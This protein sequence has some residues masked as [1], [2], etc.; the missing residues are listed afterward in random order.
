M[1]EG[2]FYAPTVGLPLITQNGKSCNPG[3]LQHSV[4][5]SLETCLPIGIPK[6]PQSLDIRKNSGRRIS[7]F[8]I[9]GQSFMNKNCHNSR[10]SNDIDM[11]LGPLIKLT[12]M[13]CRKN[14]TPLSLFQFMA[15]LEQYRDWIPDTW[16]VIITFSLMLI[17]YFTKTE[18][19]TGKSL[20]QLSHYC[21]EQGYYFWQ[22]NADISIIKK[23][24]V[25]KDIF[26]E[27]TYVRVLKY[28][29][30]SL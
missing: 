23:V 1:R 29:I 6:S 15:N 12:M 5:F 10:A 7:D 4:S 24:L 22:K 14:E 8:W 28:Q 13:S 27:I 2:A 18:N 26:S 20:T 11:K 21:F 30:S 19:K 9:S 17:F 16:S 3:I 25:L